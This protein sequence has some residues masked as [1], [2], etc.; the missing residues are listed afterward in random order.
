MSAAV[1]PNP[2]AKTCGMTLPPNETKAVVGFQG[3]IDFEAE[4]ARTALGKSQY[5][6]K[7]QYVLN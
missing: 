7:S 1:G 5:P 2:F 3:N 4:A 6:N